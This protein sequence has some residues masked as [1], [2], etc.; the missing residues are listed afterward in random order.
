MN[1]L[2]EYFKKVTIETGKLS[3]CVSVQVGAVLVKDKRIVSIGY[4]GVAPKARHCIDIFGASF[5]RDEHH[6]WS[7]YNELH[8]EQNLISFC[9]KYGIETDGT[10]LYVTTSPCIDCAKII[11]AAG[12][13]EV[14]YIKQYDKESGLPFLRD[15]DI[16]AKKLEE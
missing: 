15:N 16:V 5:D 4:N 6:E 12:I 3:T 14:F 8:A 13:K 7:K 2:A 1:K 11:C 10:T 9:S